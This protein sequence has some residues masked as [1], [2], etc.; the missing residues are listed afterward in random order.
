MS[1]I[2]NESS[3]D[4]LEEIRSMM[5]K[6]SRFLSLSGWSGLWAGIVALVSAFVAAE[7]M[8]KTDG[9]NMVVHND[10]DLIC[11]LVLLAIGTFVFALIGGIY[12][13]YQKNKKS[14][15]AIWDSTTRKM[16][17]NLF[18]PL[19]AGGIFCLAFIQ[20]QDW[21]YISGTTLIFYGLALVN[22]SKYTLTDIKYLGVL[23]I[24]LGLICLFL[25]GFGLYFW[26]IGFG[27]LHILY[28]IIMWRKY[29]SK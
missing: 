28:G 5:Q 8:G 11:H 14:K 13:T 6:S 29:E 23:E 20:N 10:T 24:V 17:V 22:A 4:A 25:P 7:L 9:Y 15:N 21:Q 12:F 3:R 16:L 27:V 26:A 1:Q 2:S 18:I 19:F